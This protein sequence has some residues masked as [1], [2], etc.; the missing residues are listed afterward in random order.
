MTLNQTASRCLPLAA[1]SLIATL[2]AP[3]SA[4]EPEAVTYREV[5]AVLK[6]QCFKC[7]SP[8]E[9]RGRLD[10]TTYGA[11]MRGSTSG[12]VVVKGNPDE[13]LLYLVVTHQ[14]EPRMPPGSPKMD[15]DRL[16]L[17][18][19]WIAAGAPERPGDAGAAAPA[20]APAATAVTGEGMNASP[21][22]RPQ[23]REASA[24]KTPTKPQP[25]RPT[26]LTAVA[27]SPDGKRLAVSDQSRV[28]L[29]EV[30][31]DS[32]KPRA[33]LPFPE[34]E[35][36]ALKFGKDG[37]TLLAAG[38]K[39]GESGTAILFETETGRRVGMYG[40]EP[41]VVLAGDVSPDGQLVA[42]GGP[43]R[44]VKVFGA[45]D[46]R[47]RHTLKR[48]TDW[49]LSVAYSPDG[50]LIATCD[51][52]GNTFVWEAETGAELHA[53]RGHN[54]AVTALGWDRSSDRL[55]TAGDDGLVNLWDMHKGSVLRSWKA[56]EKGVLGLAVAPEGAVT[57]GGRDLNVRIWAEPARES[58]KPLG[59]FGDL[60]A[61][62]APLAGG[63]WA[64][65]DWSGRLSLW[66]TSGNR[67]AQSEPI[68]LNVAALASGPA[69]I[70]SSEEPV[71][72][73]PASPAANTQAPATASDERS[74]PPARLS[75]DARSAEQT[76]AALL[77]DLQDQRKRVTEDE[78]SVQA[79]AARVASAGAATAGPS[80][81]SS[82]PRLDQLAR[83]LAEAS[84]EADALLAPVKPTAGAI[85]TTDPGRVPPRELMELATLVRLA[86]ERAQAL[87]PSSGDPRARAQAGLQEAEGRLQNS[88]RALQA[89]LDRLKSLGLSVPASETTASQSDGR[90]KPSSMGRAD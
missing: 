9:K 61:I 39:H 83:T 27:S 19:R 13:S 6:L 68:R 63:R 78:A 49:V 3:T 30:G 85:A 48:H 2:G 34:G 73:V 40:D 57:T 79:A 4:D 33:A 20:K 70:V 82:S 36:Y 77:A 56:H 87:A 90:R 15:N 75:A 66:E 59:P 12:P 81:T 25:V 76:L 60:P 41:D 11:L 28:L 32:L 74:L 53:L 52:A 42:I 71:A 67:L 51:R 58:G 37:R 23:S 64:V 84:K 18:R 55:Y 17:I 38:G 16:E 26:T 43:R 47:L 7:H 62:L 22:D 69:K 45:S 86:S 80:D 5:K 88:R 14:E 44:V 31:S 72:S 24:T 54:A 89:T 46:G 8:E 21:G 1:L 29:L 50:L 10:M 35:V 65:G